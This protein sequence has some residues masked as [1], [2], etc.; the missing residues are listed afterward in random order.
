MN[1][2]PNLKLFTK[3]NSKW[4][5]DLNV[6]CKTIKFLEDNIGEKLDNF[7]YDDAFLGTTTKTSSMKDI[8]DKQGFIKIKKFCST[9]DTVK[10][11]RRQATDWE[12]NMCK[13]HIR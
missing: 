9:N 6:K 5:I 7:G 4:I 1:L 12:K 2:D 10:R 3:V 13:S 11:M 8:V